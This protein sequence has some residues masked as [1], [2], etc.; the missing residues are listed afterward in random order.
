MSRWKGDDIYS[1]SKVSGANDFNQQLISNNRFSTDI[2][3]LSKNIVS[4]FSR[5]HQSRERR[6]DIQRFSMMLR[7]INCSLS[8]YPLPQR[9][10][11][12]FAYSSRAHQ[13]GLLK[14]ILI[15]NHKNRKFQFIY[16]IYYKPN[17]SV[18]WQLAVTTVAG[19]AGCFYK[20]RQ[21]QLAQARY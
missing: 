9:I 3:F 2:G 17:Y 14:E 10:L 1:L 8:T 4:C 6:I 18:V 11:H 12:G 19:K 20:S 16:P 7:P 5:M 21:D 13:L 15:E